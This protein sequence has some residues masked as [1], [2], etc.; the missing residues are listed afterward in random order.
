MGINEAIAE[1]Y[2]KV[3]YVQKEHS[4]GLNYSYASERAFI[5]ALRPAMVEA[6]ISVR[7]TG[8][9]VL[10]SSNFTT[11]RGGQMNRAVLRGSFLFQHIDG[12]SVL[13]QSIGEGMD[14]GDKAFNKAQTGAYKYALRQTFLIETGD[15]PDTTPSDTQERAG[16]V[17]Q[18]TERAVS[19][20]QVEGSSPSGATK[21]FD[22]PEGY[23]EMDDSGQ[24]YMMCK[25]HGK[26]TRAKYWPYN[27][28]KNFPANISCN[29]K[30]NGQYCKGRTSPPRVDALAFR[31]TGRLPAWWKAME[32]ALASM[33]V[34]TPDL[35]YLIEDYKEKDGAPYSDS[36]YKVST[37]FNSNGMSF[38]SDLEAFA[39][40]A[41][42]AKRSAD[43]AN[44]QNDLPFDE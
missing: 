9:E 23:A 33:D 41:E 35:K 42:Q 28:E 40:L 13:V 43:S 34:E 38:E 4:S 31:L 8:W 36:V 2:A 3:G 37:F 25:E 5:E 11:A 39:A 10:D 24:W 6:G 18:R 22:W 15:D 32:M 20:R 14:S 44:I 26:K 29:E 27:S 30:I 1:V 7:P 17:A 19:T 12:T 16:P 21:N